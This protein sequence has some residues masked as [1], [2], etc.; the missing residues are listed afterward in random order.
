[1]KLKRNKIDLM[2]FKAFSVLFVLNLFLILF[3]IYFYYAAVIVLF[4][5]KPL[6]NVPRRLYIIICLHFL[7]LD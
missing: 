7:G 2:N 1:M 5:Q 4:I 6:F 3:K